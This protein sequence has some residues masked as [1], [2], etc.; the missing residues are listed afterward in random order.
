MFSGGLEYSILSPIDAINLAEVCITN[1]ETYEKQT[2]KTV[3]N[4]PLDL[5]MG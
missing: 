5:R 3:L 2:G 4:G 1:R